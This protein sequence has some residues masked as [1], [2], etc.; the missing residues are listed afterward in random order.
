ML[1]IR[2]R[3]IVWPLSTLV[4]VGC[5]S[6]DPNPER[7]NGEVASGGGAGEISRA[8]APSGGQAGSGGAA[9]AAGK[10][11]AGAAGA[12]G[13][14]SSAGAAGAGGALAGAAGAAGIG[15]IGG[16]GG[17]TAGVGGVGGVGGDPLCTQV[18]YRDADS[19]GHGV[20]SD[21]TQDCTAP[22]GYVDVVGD[23]NDGD[24]NNWVS[25]ATCRDRDADGH[26]AGCD[27]YVTLKG[28]D[29]D[30]VRPWINKEMVDAPPLGPADT[31]DWD[32]NG[33]DIAVDESVGTFVSPQ[34]NDSN[35]GTRAL[36]VQTLRRG[37][38]IAESNQLYAVFVAGGYYAE[39]VSTSVSIF[40][41]Y[42]PNTWERNALVHLTA[43]AAPSDAAI[44]VASGSKVALQGFEV[45]GSS[46]ATSLVSSPLRATDATFV[47][48]SV[49]VS[50][51]SN[52]TLGGEVAG[53][54]QDN[55]NAFII[56][57]DVYS[58]TADAG[59]FGVR[60]S[61]GWAYFE[62][63]SV[64]MSQVAPAMRS[65]GVLLEPGARGTVWRSSVMGGRAQTSYG[66]LTESSGKLDV[67][68]SL[69]QSGTST[70]AW[71]EVEYPPSCVAVGFSGSAALLESSQFSSGEAGG[72]CFVSRA[73]DASG[74]LTVVNALLNAGQ[75]GSGAALVQRTGQGLVVSSTLIGN[76]GLEGHA[77]DLYPGTA[78][79]A[80]NSII[81]FH[82]ES[83]VRARGAV[84]SLYNDIWSP[85]SDCLVRNSLYACTKSAQDV[86][87]KYCL[88]PSCGNISV[89]PQFD[90][91]LQISNASPCVNAGI[92]PAPWFSGPI[93]DLNGQ[94]RPLGGKYDQGAFEV[95]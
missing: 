70:G 57:S 60:A 24:P 8:G 12:G 83:G 61:Q 68:E 50:G 67:L 77:W 21:T 54:L 28:E 2:N 32:C 62:E 74:G 3:H 79:V 84:Q 89:D 11:T 72:N 31:E 6:Q 19:D 82:A 48:H 30:D 90:G 52:Q 20:A 63:S 73:V 51:G 9:G 64:S 25:C 46:A 33:V 94:L 36:P 80:V 29:C 85:T 43:I 41:G 26:F 44:H 13:V 65:A 38:E 59:T 91:N 37:I 22:A 15:G 75:A 17:S 5:G 18:F 53:I 95:R 58:G 39:D 34:G 78:S 66:I 16:I 35:P 7:G 86:N 87:S 76:E 45:Q 27:A 40:G 47:L 81:E 93:T 71:T 55:S 14:P 10:Q 88:L 49:R 4:L 92:D 69:V 56:K 1:R 23:C 42:D